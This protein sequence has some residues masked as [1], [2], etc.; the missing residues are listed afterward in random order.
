MTRGGSEGP[1]C[2]RCGGTLSSVIR[3]PDELIQA[4]KRRQR[5]C[6]NCGHRWWT[7]ERNEDATGSVATVAVNHDN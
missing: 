3:V 5:E 7:L 2:A 1:P 4:Q 6:C